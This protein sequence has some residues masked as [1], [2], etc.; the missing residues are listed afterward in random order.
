VNREC[1][2]G[3]WG[4]SFGEWNWAPAPLKRIQ[5]RYGF[6][7]A[8]VA[9]GSDLDGFIKPTLAG[10]EHPGHLFRLEQALAQRFGPEAAELIS[11]ANALHLLRSRWRAATQ[12]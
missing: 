6:Q 2:A 5:R 12:S 1:E 9:L 3:H 4:G 11:S 8:Y 10:F 7:E